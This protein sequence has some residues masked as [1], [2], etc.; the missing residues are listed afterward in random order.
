MKLLSLKASAPT[1]LIQALA[2]PALAT[3]TSTPIVLQEGVGLGV[4]VSSRAVRLLAVSPAS[5]FA[6]RKC[7]G[8]IDISALPFGHVR[9]Q[10]PHYFAGGLAHEIPTPHKIASRSKSTSL[11]QPSTEKSK[12]LCQGFVIQLVSAYAHHGLVRTKGTLA[13]QEPCGPRNVNVRRRFRRQQRTSWLPR[14]SLDCRSSLTSVGRIP[15]SLFSRSSLNHVR[16]VPY[17]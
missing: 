9:S 13:F 15:G 5:R 6:K 8:R 16:S 12:Q 3:C 10:S 4:R 11:R 1:L 7:Q 2:F 14:T 17:L